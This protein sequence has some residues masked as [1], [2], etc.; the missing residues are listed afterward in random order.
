MSQADACLQTAAASAFP[1]PTTSPAP[2]LR[3]WN[4]PLACCEQHMNTTPFPVRPPES[5]QN[6]P[7]CSHR[8]LLAGPLPVDWAMS[9]A[10]AALQVMVF[11]SNK[12]TGAQSMTEC[13]QHCCALHQDLASL[14][15][16]KLFIDIFHRSYASGCL[17]SQ[18]H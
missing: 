8:I 11:A 16:H 6:L 1:S 12:L 18:L 13:R 15:G 3:T 9:G 7:A 14:S 2:V 4:L 10:F 17:A 5:Y